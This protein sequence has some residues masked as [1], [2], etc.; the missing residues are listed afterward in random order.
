MHD[1]IVTS[2]PEIY[3]SIIL[4]MSAFVYPDS[5]QY[6]PGNVCESSAQTHP[7][8][9]KCPTKS[10]R[11]HIDCWVSFGPPQ[12]CVCDRHLCGAVCLP[13]NSRCKPPIAPLNGTVRFN[14]TEIGDS[15]EYTCEVGFV[16][17]GPRN[18]HC[19]ATLSWSGEDPS[20]SNQTNT[21]F[22]PPYMPNTRTRS[23]PRPEQVSMFSLDIDRDDYKSGE[24]IEIVCQPGYKDLER[25]YVEAAC[26]GSEW[27]V[28]KLNCERVNCG[29]IRDPPHGHL[30]FKSDKRYKAEALA[31]CAEGFIADCGPSSGT[32]DSTI[33]C[34]RVCQADG[35]WSGHDTICRPIT[36][37]R[38]DAPENG[39]IST[40]STE[41][42]SIVKVHCNHGYELIGPEQKQC[43]A[44]GKWD[45]ERTICKE[46]DCGPVPT[47]VNGRVT[48]EKTTFGSRAAFTCDPDTTASSDT[49]SLHCGLIDNKTSW[50]PQPIPTCNRHCYLF[51]VDHGDVLL[52]HKPNTPSQRFIPITSE[53]YP[54]LESIGNALTSS[55]GIILPGS[56]VR[57]GAQLNV[58]CHRGYQLVN[59]AQPIT[60]CMDGVWSVRSKC[61]PASCRTRPPPAPGARVRFYSLK[62]EA[63]G[64]YE[65]FVGHTLRVDETKQIVQPLNAVGSNDDPLGVIRCLHGEWVGIPVFCEPVICSKLILHK[66]V[67]VELKH[68]TSRNI[69]MGGTATLEETPRQGTVAHFR[70][71]PGFHVVGTTFSVCHNGTWTP[72]PNT[73]HCEKSTHDQIPTEWF[74]RIT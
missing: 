42:N 13:E 44:T 12:F 33:G 67:E 5:A 28:T 15:A 3:F 30:V 39:G 31:V 8:F 48:A 41:V 53:N 69:L 27:R 65:C 43:L 72:P 7:D 26:V 58:T 54:Q 14:G 9:M 55:D 74:F 25:D 36:C 66:M 45:G 68:P 70:C 40:Y 20:C 18:R 51:T 22:S 16:V 23:R 73:A 1:N 52:M 60:M 37:P 71:S 46:R 24:V 59:T 57:H 11:Q 61:V 35:T 62:H 6:T 32:Q 56:R 47:V 21:C 49:D 63:K 19:L 29:P 17:R 38:L 2:R 50:L 4:W 10:C 64:R 34:L